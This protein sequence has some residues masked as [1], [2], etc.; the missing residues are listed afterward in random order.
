MRKILYVTPKLTKAPA[1]RTQE[2]TQMFQQI[3]IRFYY[4]HSGWGHITQY[5]ILLVWQY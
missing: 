4:K 5:L 1:Y 2:R 3:L